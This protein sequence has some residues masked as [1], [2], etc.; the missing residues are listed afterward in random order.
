MQNAYR[1]ACVAAAAALVACGS[2]PAD[3][4]GADNTDPVVEEGAC[5][6]LERCCVGLPES[7]RGQCLGGARA[8]GDAECTTALAQLR[9]SGA[10][11]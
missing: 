9:G 10:C 1:I 2:A 6:K 7:D 5:E 3:F 4:E 11:R 8:G